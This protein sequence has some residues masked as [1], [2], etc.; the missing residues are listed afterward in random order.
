MYAQNAVE[1][2]EG[3]ETSKVVQNAKFQAR[4]KYLEEKLSSASENNQDMHQM[5]VE[6]EKEHLK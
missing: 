3:L 4:L 5:K 2:R 6:I 1:L